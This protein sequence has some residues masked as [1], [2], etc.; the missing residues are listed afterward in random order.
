MSSGGCDARAPVA[1]AGLRRQAH[2]VRVPG[3][4]FPGA[5]PQSALW[6]AGNTG[7]E[8]IVTAAAAIRVE[9]PAQPT[10]ER[11]ESER[12]KSESS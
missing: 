3:N 7:S 6:M 5:I 1:A 4:R 10:R 2:R 12:L 11:I 8:K 9:S